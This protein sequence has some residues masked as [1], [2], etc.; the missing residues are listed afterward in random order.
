[1]VR[2]TQGALSCLKTAGIDGA[3]IGRVG[4]VWSYVVIVRSNGLL[5]LVMRSG[6][7]AAIAGLGLRLLTPE[8]FDSV[9]S[10]FAA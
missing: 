9:I 10:D 7:I 1:M 6:N 4:R 5:R 2:L 3:L 8:S